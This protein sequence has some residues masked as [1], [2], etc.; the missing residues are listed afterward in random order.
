MLESHS[1]H[2]EELS[3]TSRASKDVEDYKINSITTYAILQLKEESESIKAS[4]KIQYV[5][6]DYA[7]K[8][9]RSVPLSMVGTNYDVKRYGKLLA[10]CCLS[11]TK[12]FGM[13][14]DSFRS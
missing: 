6:T 2:V 8:R 4:Q 9:K 14:E 11:I 13:N 3:F 12:S 5:I 1:V 10:E 7:R